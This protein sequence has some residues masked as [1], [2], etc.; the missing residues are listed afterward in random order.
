M[1]LPTIDENEIGTV[2]M[3]RDNNTVR[4]GEVTH[5]YKDEKLYF[6]V[7]ENGENEKISF[8]QLDRYRCT[9]TDRDTSKRI[10]RL[11]TRLQR[12]N[13]ATKQRTLTTKVPN[14]FANVVYDEEI[15]KMLDHKNS[16]IIETRKEE[17]GGSNQQQMNLERYSRESDAIKMEHNA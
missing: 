9:D 1:G 5:Y 12:A 17:N 7:Y 11:S 3:K 15:G 6:I 13:L 14:H 2:I 10:T 16:S 8:Q 4:R